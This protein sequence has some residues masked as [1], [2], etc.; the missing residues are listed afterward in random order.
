ML[1]TIEESLIKK[2]DGAIHTMFYHMLYSIA[3][4]IRKEGITAFREELL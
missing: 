1:N 4:L 3:M 2:F